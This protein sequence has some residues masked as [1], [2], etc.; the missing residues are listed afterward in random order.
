M[1]RYALRRV[2]Q[3]V[4]VMLFIAVVNFLL[5]HLAPGDPAAALAGE[6]APQE[7]IEALRVDYGLDKPLLQQLGTYLSTLLQ[8]DLGYSFAYRRPVVEVIVERLPATA[9]LVFA[10]QIPAIVVGTLLGAYSARHYPSKIDNAVTAVSLSLYAVPIF[11]SGLLLILVFAVWLRWL[12]ASGMFS[13]T[14]PSEGLGRFLDIARHM[15]LPTTALFLYSLPTY[16]RLTRASVIEIMRED[17]ITTARAIGYSENVVFFRHALRNALLPAVTVAGLSLSFVFAGALLTET[18]FGWPGMG[19]LMYEGV[20]K[21]DYP[22]LMG[23]FLVTSALVLIV[24]IVTD[25]IYAAL[26]PRV[27]Y[28]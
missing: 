18:V 26:D 15:A 1:R 3:I 8:G 28:E 22:V 11:W 27:S 19:R 25:L 4:P 13:L 17:F 2:V 7:F 5:I 12:P 14:A 16:V 23:V 20:L 9:L 24:G 6:G 21:R 10:S